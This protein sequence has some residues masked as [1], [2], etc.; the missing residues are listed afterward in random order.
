MTAAHGKVPEAT[1]F[2][3]LT[4][5][6]NGIYMCYFCGRGIQDRV[7]DPQL[8]HAR[9]FDSVCAHCSRTAF[10]LLSNISIN[11]MIRNQQDIEYVFT[12]LC[13][14]KSFALPSSLSAFPRWYGPL[15]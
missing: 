3:L 2:K 8:Q 1:Y 10:Q 6:N 13:P 5:G 11:T 15:A 7:W 12:E 9:L 4:Y 14:H